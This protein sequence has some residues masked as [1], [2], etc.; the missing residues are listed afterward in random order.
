MVGF[1]GGLFLFAMVYGA[2]DYCRFPERN[3]LLGNGMGINFDMDIATFTA[4]QVGAALYFF[5]DFARNFHQLLVG[6]VGKYFFNRVMLVVG[7]S[8]FIDG[9]V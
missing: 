6:W 2:S 1:D 3:A 7:L 9:L 8:V 5:D 4:K